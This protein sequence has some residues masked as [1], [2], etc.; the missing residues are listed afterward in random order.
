MERM[1][2]KTGNYFIDIAMTKMPTT[3]VLVTN[4]ANSAKPKPPVAAAD[5]MVWGRRYVGNDY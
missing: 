5:P 1:Q 2:L 3:A 4:L